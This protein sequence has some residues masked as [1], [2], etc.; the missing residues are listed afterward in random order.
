MKKASSNF[1]WFLILLWVGFNQVYWRLGPHLADYSDQSLHTSASLLIKGVTAIG[2]DLLL[3]LL[4]YL[5]ATRVNKESFISKAWLNTLVLGVLTSL[6]VA[7]SSNK[8]NQ[9]TSFSTSFFDALFP[10]LRNSYPLIFGAILGLLLFS[11]ISQLD[12]TWQRRI[13]AGTWMLIAIPF[14]NYPNNWGWSDNHLTIFYGLLFLIGAQIK[15]PT[16]SKRLIGEGIL[17]LGINTVL[18]G[19]MPIFSINGETLNRYSEPS[20]VLIVFIAYVGAIVAGKYIVHFNLRLIFSFLVLVENNALISR[21]LLPLKI[22]DRHSTIK[23]GIYT[24]LFLLSALIF[25][26]LWVA[27][28]KCPLFRKIDRNVTTLTNLPL[29]QQRKAIKRLLI[30]QVPNIMLAGI[31]YVLAASSML[32]MN[33]GLTVSPN[34]NATYNVFAYTFVARQL[35]VVVTAVLIF[36]TAKF[37]QAI[38]NRYWVSLIS[39]ILI[40]AIIIVANRQKIAARNE[41]ILPSDLLLA[42]VAKDIFG[43]LSI[44]LWIIA[45]ILLLGAII[46]TIWLEK[47]YPIKATWGMKKRICFILLAPIIF[48][49]S[50]FWNHQGTLMNNFMTSIDDQPMFYNQLSGARINGPLLQF[51]NNID[52][53]VMDKPSGYS[54][55]TMDKIMFKYSLRAN[56][57]N[58]TRSN[59]LAQQNII[60]NLSESFANPQ[61]VPGVSLKNNPVPYITKMMKENTG[62]L[63]VSSGYGGGTANMEYMT[64]TGLTL[65][66]F[67]PTLPTPYTQLV[68]RLQQNP[69][70]VNSFTYAVAIH[71]YSGVFYNRIGVYQKFGFNK[72]LY[73]GSK[74]PIKHQKK[75]DQSPYLSDETSYANVLDQLKGKQNSQFINLV[76]MQNHFP[77]DQHFYRSFSQYEVTKVSPGTNIDAVNDF[78]AGIH[79]TD[80]AVKAFIREID[81][82]NKPITIVFYGDHLPGIYANKMGKDGLKL[83]ETDYFI[84]SN[85][86]A[87]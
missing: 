44:K 1:L 39:V 21:L 66:N 50:L 69:S 48:S 51:M 72:F 23:I 47:H 45:V 60:F 86:Y 4:G 33:N 43:M 78:T 11:V 63:M 26:V 15:H 20:N 82:I 71:P 29:G 55:Q 87:R 8:L 80:N 68:S 32:L 31:A 67:S 27:L 14:F 22:A 13:N 56:E 79:H 58:Y 35:L 41:P 65:S 5:V 46:L 19:F 61:H 73:L 53:T 52:V 7:I 85:I 42:S 9:V 6:L 54:K 38:T 2:P 28:T 74:Y 36:S 64:L 16:S 62:G 59:N 37:I 34:V 10:L 18:Q 17:V 81:K 57:I 3:I 49:T 83:H 40:N 25:A 70:I 12:A 24:V 84:Y 77:Y 30:K 76:T 75:I